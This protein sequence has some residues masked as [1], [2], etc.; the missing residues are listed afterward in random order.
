MLYNPKT[1][2]LKPLFAA[3]AVLP[4][5]VVADNQLSQ[6]VV[7]ANNTEQT[8]DTVTAN[9]H[10]I[11]REE[12]EARQYQTLT[13]ALTSVPSVTFGVNGGRGHA[14]NVYI[15]GSNRVLVL[16]NGIPLNDPSSIANTVNFESLQL[17]DIERIEIIRGAQSAIWGANAAAG[18]IN[19]ITQ[20][21]TSQGS[22][23]AG[24]ILG[25]NGYSQLSTSLQLVGE[26]VDASYHFN[27]TKTDGVTQLKPFKTNQNNFERD[28]YEQTDVSLAIG[29]NPTQQQRIETF[30]KQTT[31]DADF[32][33]QFA[34]DKSNDSE[35]TRQVK[36]TI[37]QL[38]YQLRSNHFELTSKVSETEIER[39]EGGG[40]NYLGKQDQK[41]LQ[42]QKHYR[43]YDSTQISI[44]QSNTSSDQNDL[45]VNNTALNL[46]NQNQFGKFT[47]NQALRYD[48]FNEFKNKTTGRVG[49]AYAINQHT[50]LSSNIGTAYTAP[51]LYQLTYG[52]TKNL[53]P[54]ETKDWD[55]RID[56]YGFGI[57][58]FNSEIHDMIEYQAIGN[59]GDPDYDD[60]FY[61]LAGKS[62]FSG[63]ELD[64]SRDL[65]PIN[66]LLSLQYSQLK[67]KDDQGVTLARRPKQT[68]ALDLQFYGIHATKINW[69]TRYIGTKYDYRNDGTQQIGQYFVSDLTVNFTVNNHISLHAKV[70]NLFNEDY[71]D[72]VESAKDTTPTTV[73]ANGGQQFFIGIRANL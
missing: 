18:V 7:T 12:I 38:S 32:D 27:N 13:D 41:S 10:V 29:L 25:N 61:N 37:R 73:Y 43:Q 22:A 60:Y 47:L 63:W 17:D 2:T 9:M 54:E 52:S 66:T 40:F 21:A 67:A 46:F 55:I 30:V 14:A 34:T 15:R 62:K 3:L 8:Q 59:W 64:Y 56:T 5:L 39:T 20:K 24:L 70:K 65:R 57:S 50:K 53:R 69:H 42:L 4:G 26:D 1:R 6:I 68:A 51:S 23:R 72:A 33:S 35:S 11:T 31:M 36:S 19:I 58:Y 16:L 45:N 71:T 44:A 28:G 49:A 48:Q